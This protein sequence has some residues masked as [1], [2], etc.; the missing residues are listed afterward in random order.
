MDDLFRIV[1]VIFWRL[2]VWGLEV[3][4]QLSLALLRAALPAVEEFLMVAARVIIRLLQYP[5]SWTII[6]VLV[7]W[8]LTDH[9]TIATSAGISAIA[10]VLAGS[11][12]RAHV[13]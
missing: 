9:G 8:T 1:E 12:V 2:F 7:L 4:L 5:E 13:W 10:T 3:A 6:A 11:L